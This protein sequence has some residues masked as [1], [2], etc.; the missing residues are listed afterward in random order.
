MTSACSKEAVEIRIT[1]TAKDRLM[2]ISVF[3][4]CPCKK[5]PSRCRRDFA[6]SAENP[7]YHKFSISATFKVPQNTGKDT[8]LTF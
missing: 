8:F 2:L 6:G 1:K 4:I 5:Q 7:L 3:M